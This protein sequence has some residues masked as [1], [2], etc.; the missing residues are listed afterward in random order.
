LTTPFN[1]TVL[2]ASE[3]IKQSGKDQAKLVHDFLKAGIDYS[4]D[5][6]KV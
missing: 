2:R 3:I 4:K 5:V 6:L 1:G